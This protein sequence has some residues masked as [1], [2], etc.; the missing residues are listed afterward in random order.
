MMKKYSFGEFLKKHWYI[1]LLLALVIPSLF[2]GGVW[3]K[4]AFCF[5]RSDWI[6]F[7]GS[8]LSYLGTVLVSLVAVY[9]SGKATHLSEMVY[10]LSEQDRYTLFAVESVESSTPTNCCNDIVARPNVPLSKMHF[11][12]VDST[13]EK[14]QGFRIRVLNCGKYPIT[15]VKIKTTY[16][17]GR[18]RTEETLNRDCNSVIPSNGEQDYFTCNYPY[19]TSSGLGPEFEITCKNIFDYCM[20]IKL[21]IKNCYKQ[22]ATGTVEYSCEVLEVGKKYEDGDNS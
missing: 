2:V 19:F 7:F 17:V 8:I 16:P 9:Q 14:C 3:W 20:T 6:A 12:K 21:N 1:I 11:C 13:P 4:S 15:Y 5:K 22:N 18:N 10:E